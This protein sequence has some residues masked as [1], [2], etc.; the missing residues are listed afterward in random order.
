MEWYIWI[1]LGLGILALI[2]YFV[3]GKAE[4]TRTESRRRTREILKAGRYDDGKEVDKLIEILELSGTTEDKHL[5]QK[6][7][8]L[9]DKAG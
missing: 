9:K 8:E 6:L 3:M 1:T 5:L 4:K 7:L 2:A